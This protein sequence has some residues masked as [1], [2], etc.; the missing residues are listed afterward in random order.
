MLSNVNTLIA[1]YT[2]EITA[3]GH[4]YSQ[5][6]IDE[7]AAVIKAAGRNWN[8]VIVKESGDN[9]YEV[10]GN[11]FV[12]QATIAA[13]LERVWVIIADDSAE[14]AA[15]AEAGSVQPVKK[16][17]KKATKK[18][19]PTQKATPKSA[20]SLTRKELQAFLKDARKA[21]RIAKKFSLNQSNAKLQEAYNQ[22]TAA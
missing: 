11:E 4:E 12:L 21:G 8:P 13:G 1:L 14:T 18:P 20:K 16:S 17:A 7:A 15:S 6:Q 9:Q 2:D 5:E 19:Q 22:L 3:Q 10:I